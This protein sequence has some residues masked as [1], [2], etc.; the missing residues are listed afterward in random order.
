M[1]PIFVSYTFFDLD[2]YRASDCD[3]IRQLGAIEIA[4]DILVLVTNVQMTCVYGLSGWKA[5]HLL[6]KLR[7][8]TIM[9][10]NLLRFSRFTS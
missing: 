3:I 10:N 1:L 7:V 5:K 2:D 6:E 9:I 8:K 4:M